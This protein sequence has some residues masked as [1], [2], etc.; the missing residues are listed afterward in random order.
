MGIPKNT[1]FSSAWLC[2]VHIQHATKLS[3]R[4]SYEK[5]AGSCVQTKKSS[6]VRLIPPFWSI[7][8]DQFCEYLDVNLALYQA[9]QTARGSYIVTQSLK[10]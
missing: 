7:Y 9:Q 3:K 2:C 1:R 10:R 5:L 8:S 4:Q 6:E